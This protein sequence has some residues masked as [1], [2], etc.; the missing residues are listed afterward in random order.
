MVRIVIGALTDASILANPSAGK[1]YTAMGFHA[2]MFGYLARIFKNGLVD[3]LDKPSTRK[4][5]FERIFNFMVNTFFNQADK[6]QEV[7][8]NGCA[9][10]IIEIIENVFS[11]LTHDA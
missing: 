1:N 8:S 9:I 2:A 5:T 6:S 11:E 4:K 7:I 3:P 10:S